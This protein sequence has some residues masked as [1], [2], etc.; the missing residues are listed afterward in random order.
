MTVCCDSAIPEECSHSPGEG[1]SDGREMYKGGQTMV[2][3]VCGELVDQM[4]N[5]DNFSAPEVVT[6]PE[7]DP[8]E[9]EDVVQDEVG[10]DICGGC[11]DRS[12]F[13]EQV[14]DIAELGKKKQDPSTS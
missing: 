7:E 8:G 9:D 6:G 10:R 4:G 11:D 5:D 14:P 3:P 2:S 13:G 12:I 1:T